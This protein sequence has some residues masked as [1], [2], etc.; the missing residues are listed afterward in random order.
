M[1]ELQGR[2]FVEGDSECEAALATAYQ[3]QYR[4]L[5]RCM[6]PSIAMYIARL[7]TGYIVKRM[8]NTGHRRASSC[9]SYEPPPGM[10]GLGGLLGTAIRNRES[11]EV[12]TLAVDFPMSMAATRKAEAAREKSP[13]SV[14]GRRL[15]MSQHAVLHYLLEQAGLG[16]W[17]PAMAGKRSWAVVRSLVRK[18]AER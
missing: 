12:T 8:P 4:P 11:D 16:K 14:R 2:I 9:S 7:R 5:C 3:S 17:A 6:L 18:A 1:F 13:V 10:S 15:R